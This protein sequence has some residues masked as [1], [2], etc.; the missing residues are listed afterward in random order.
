M[1]PTTRVHIFRWFC[2]FVVVDRYHVT[3]MLLVSTWLAAA[4]VVPS[5]TLS[6]R[7]VCCYAGISSSIFFNLPLILPPSSAQINC[8]ESVLLPSLCNVCAVSF[9]HPLSASLLH[10]INCSGFARQLLCD[11]VLL[12]SMLVTAVYIPRSDRDVAFD[13]ANTL[14][15]IYSSSIDTLIE[16]VGAGI[17]I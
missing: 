15:S 9:S 17:S 16:P 6:A 2:S 1:A 7:S 3:I 4:V 5:L 14:S 10:R 13:L 11:V 8:S 12:C